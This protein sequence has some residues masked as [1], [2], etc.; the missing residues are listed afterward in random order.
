M[1]VEWLDWQGLVITIV[2]LK[3]FHVVV[4]L[5]LDNGREVYIAHDDGTIALD[6]VKPPTGMM[7]SEFSSVCLLDQLEGGLFVC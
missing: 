7:I 6:W 3:L 5:T 1:S 2:E 4:F